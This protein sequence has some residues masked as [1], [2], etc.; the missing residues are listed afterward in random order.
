MYFMHD[1]D[2][3]VPHLFGL[4]AMQPRRL[5]RRLLQTRGTDHSLKSAYQKRWRE[6]INWIGQKRFPPEADLLDSIRQN[7]ERGTRF[8]KQLSIEGNLVDGPWMRRCKSIADDVL[9][10]KDLRLFKHDSLRYSMIVEVGGSW[11]HSQLDY[12]SSQLSDETL[13]ELLREPRI[14]GIPVNSIRFGCSHNNIHHLHHLVSFEDCSGIKI[15]DLRW[16][17]EF[18]G[19]YGNMARLVKM[20]SPGMTYLIIDLPI[21]LLIQFAYLETFL[22]RGI[23]NF[24]V[25]ADQPL[26]EFKINL[27]VGQS[28]Y[29]IEHEFD[30][31][32]STMAL[33]ETSPIAQRAVL[34]ARFFGAEHLLISHQ[35]TSERW[36][37]AESFVGPISQQY[38]IYLQERLSY[39]D[40]DEAYLFARK[41][42][43]RTD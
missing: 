10:S 4:V 39:F 32:I 7:I 23:C 6:F 5:A 37:Y 12:L 2:R 20:M 25:E 26:E 22:G 1:D 33:S 15:S 31:F 27:I 36:K 13:G 19:G 24:V 35:S 21:F 18:G 38:E 43:A 17:V 9:H 16:I 34:E 3:K 28:N 8:Y 29:A 40:K 11:M 14:E 41:R 42:L 30:L